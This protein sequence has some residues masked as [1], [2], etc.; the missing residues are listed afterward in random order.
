MIR[1]MIA[2]GIEP[3]AIAGRMRCG[4]RVDERSDVARQERVDQHEVRGQLEMEPGID[5]AGRRQDLQLDGED[6][7][8]G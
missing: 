4:E 6:V 8:E 5:P 1:V 7:L 2:S 3:S